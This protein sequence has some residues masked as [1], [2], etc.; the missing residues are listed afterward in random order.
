MKRLVLALQYWEGD[1][2]MAMRNARRIADNEPAFRSDVEFCFVARFDCSHDRET[3]QHVAKKFKVTSYRGTRRG[4]GW[5]SGCNDLWCDLMQEAVRRHLGGQQWSDVKAIFTF[6]ADAIPIARNWIDV[7][8]REWDRGE[9][10]GKLVVGSHHPSGTEFG[11]INGN[12]L[13]SPLVALKL[14]LVGCDPLVGWDVAFAPQ[15]R[16]HWLPIGTIKNLYKSRGLSD[17]DILAEHFPGIAPVMI[18][19]VKDDS[20]ERYADRVLRKT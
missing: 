12:A 11:H 7:L 8:G 19:G 2:E 20:V 14:G 18:H 1:K 5:P 4:Q 16:A 10:Q 6:E 13:F 17:K 3:M 15:M 9:A